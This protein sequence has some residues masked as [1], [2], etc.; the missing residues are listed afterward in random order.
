MLADRPRRRARREA[1]ASPPPFTGAARLRRQHPQARRR[2]GHVRAPT[3]SSTTSAT[4]T[5]RCSPT[6]SLSDA[7]DDVAAQGR[8]LLQLRRQR[9]RRS[10][11][12]DS[13]VRLVPAKQGVKGTNLDLS[14]GRPGAV[15]RRPAGHEPRR[16]HRRRPGHASS[17][18]DGGMIDLQWD[19][20]VDLDGATFG[21]PLLSRPPARSR[22]R[23]R[24]RASTFTPT[25]DQVGQQVAVPHRRAS[26][27][28]P[29]TSI[30]SV[31]RPRR[32]RPGRRSTPAPRP[33]CL[34]P[35]CPR[36]ATYDDHDHRLRR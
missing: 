10:K 35:P 33:R 17:A 13:R 26:R 22:T 25:A 29:R 36:P 16:R 31:D 27:R 1:A 11:S 18:T 15:R 32:H 14:R 7:I 3:S 2:D 23:T 8:A 5:S 20:P 6:A 4:S 24:R 12:W 21:D 19:D 28:G 9:G 30:L 34:P